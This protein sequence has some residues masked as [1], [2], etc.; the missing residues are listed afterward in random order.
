MPGFAE[1]RPQSYRCLQRRDSRIV[2]ICAVQEIT[3]IVIEIG[4]RCVRMLLQIKG[5][6]PG[7]IFIIACCGDPFRLGNGL[8]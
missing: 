6:P 5:Q 1:S 8:A 4:T 7:R 3:Q 2:F